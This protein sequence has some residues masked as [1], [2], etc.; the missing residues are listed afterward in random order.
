MKTTTKHI[1]FLFEVHQPFR[2]K[3]YHFF[4]IGNDN[5]YYDH[6]NNARLLLSIAEES[7]LPTVQIL[8]DLINTY[9]N[10][11]KISFAISGTALDQMQR[12]APHVLESFQRLAATGNVEFIGQTN[13][14]SLFSAT[15]MNSFSMEVGLHK[16]AIEKHFRQLPSTFLNTGFI[17]SEQLCNTIFELGFK[18]IITTDEAAVVHG[19]NQYAIYK[20]NSVKP[21][22]FL[23]RNSSLSNDISF[24]FSQKDWSEWPL[25]ADKYISWLKGLQPKEKIV[26]ITMD[27]TSFGST[28]KSNTGIFSFLK[29][30]MHYLAEDKEM[31]LSTPQEAL[32][33]HQP[34][35]QSFFPNSYKG[36]KSVGTEVFE[37]EL[38]M[39]AFKSL[40]HLENKLGKLN[41]QQLHKD[42]SYLQSAD[43]FY[44]M[45]DNGF[46]DN[47]FNPYNSPYDA[48]L[49]YMNVLTDFSLRLEN[50][51]KAVATSIPLL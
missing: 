40:Y 6:E 22:K 46:F 1:S 13:S 32:E 39:E 33:S 23:L 5:N 10:S 8:M 17:L 21:L 48:F 20:N 36:S 41:N 30:L 44:Y 18:A 3:K 51:N 15:S 34:R 28:H 42:W 12:Y 24:R 27:C 19:K 35:S 29:F 14:R 37:N 50:A 4:D 43:H 26:T 49:N 31:I 9:G 47:Y 45:S 7:Y 38:Q 25:T 11:I 16:K 2:L